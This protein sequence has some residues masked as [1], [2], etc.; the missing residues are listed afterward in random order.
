MRKIVYPGDEI[1][2]RPIR[3]PYVYVKDDKS[4]AEVIGVLDENGRYIPLESP[5]IPRVGDIVVGIVTDVR[6]IGY[7]VDLNIPKTALLPQRDTHIRFRLGDFVMGKIKMVD[8][9]GNVDITEARKLTKGKVIEFPSAKIPRLIGK[10]GSMLS[11]IK[12]HVGED[13]QV[14]KNGYVWIGER[15]NI[16]LFLKVLKFIEHHAPQSGLTDKVAEMLEGE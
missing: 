12:E 14:G 3:M 9:S 5:Y 8:R 10:Q 13:I 4:Y 2:D 1:S 15:S 6:H 16:P 7:G 11:M